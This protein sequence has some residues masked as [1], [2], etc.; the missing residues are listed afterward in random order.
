M[1]IFA[2]VFI[3]CG[4]AWIGLLDRSIFAPVMLKFIVI[5]TS[6]NYV[7]YWMYNFW[8]LRP[9]LP[10]SLE[11]FTSSVKQPTWWL[12]LLSRT[13]TCEAFV[14]KDLGAAVAVVLMQ[15]VKDLVSFWPFR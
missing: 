10:K 6:A 12:W 4:A 2:V 1:L 8:T 9:Y 14:H 3:L 7:S 15:L 5:W 13:F 11:S